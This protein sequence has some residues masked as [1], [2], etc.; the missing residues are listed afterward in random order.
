M[1]SYLCDF[2]SLRMVPKMYATTME[3]KVVTMKKIG[4]IHSSRSFADHNL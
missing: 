1:K 4:M 3:T 2:F